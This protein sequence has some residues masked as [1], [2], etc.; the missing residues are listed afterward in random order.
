M[1]TI[2]LDP[3]M[4]QRLRELATARGQDVQELARHV[5]EEYLDL[6]SWGKDRAEDWAEASAALAP[7]IM[8][9]DTWTK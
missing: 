6:Q 4:E 2:D 8:P 5:L 1:V 3:T 9:E 7:E